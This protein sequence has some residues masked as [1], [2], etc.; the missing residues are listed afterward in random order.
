MAAIECPGGWVEDG[1]HP[2]LLEY[3]YPSIAITPANS[4]SNGD[5]VI[6]TNSFSK[7][8][9]KRIRAELKVN[10]KE[11]FNLNG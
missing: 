3:P 1:E 2:F 9:M 8:D 4:K 7:L 5:I 11:F 6:N 10:L